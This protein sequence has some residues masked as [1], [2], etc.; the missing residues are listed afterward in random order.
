MLEAVTLT[1]SPESG[2]SESLG[3][4]LS[5][6]ATSPSMGTNSVSWL[7]LKLSLTL[8]STEKDDQYDIQ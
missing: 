5:C 7:N 2:L 6:D 3:G 8:R 4:E 1:R